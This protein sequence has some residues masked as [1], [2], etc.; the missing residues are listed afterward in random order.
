VSPADEARLPGGSSA[1]S[2]ARAAVRAWLAGE[3]PADTLNAV[4]LMVSE[5]VTNSVVHGG[6]GEDGWI[7]LRASHADGRLLVDVRD[8]GR[9]GEPHR[10]RPDLDDGTGGLGL[11]IVEQLADRWGSDR[12][13]DLRVWFEVETAGAASPGEPAAR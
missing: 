7:D 13:P 2:R 11:L 10:R 1:P 6:V 8:S 3:L 9:Q 4:Q 12:E 5:I